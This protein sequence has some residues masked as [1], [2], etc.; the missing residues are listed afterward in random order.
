MNT[1]AI[2]GDD[3]DR[4]RFSI[5]AGKLCGGDFGVMPGLLRCAG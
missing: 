1:K 3:E 4:D 5:I 2:F